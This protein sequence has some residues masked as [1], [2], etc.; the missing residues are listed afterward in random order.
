M[1][2][3]APKP[4]RQTIT[5][6][7]TV[8]ET[9]HTRKYALRKPYVPKDPRHLRAVIPGLIVAVQVQPG[10]AVTRGQ[11]VLVLEAMKMQ[12]L[13]LAPRAGRVREV[14]VSAGQ[15]VAKGALLVVFE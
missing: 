5:L 8:Y 2:A 9:T 13:L 12:N 15:T 3:P 7:D 10:D 14:H 4:Q 1:N 11:G 6:N